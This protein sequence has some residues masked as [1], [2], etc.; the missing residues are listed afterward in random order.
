MADWYN[1]A[2]ARL[3]A[4]PSRDERLNVGIIVFDGNRLDVRPAR[5]LDKIRA[6]SAAIDSQAVRDSILRLNVLD[7]IVQAEGHNSLT[8]R[9]AALRLICPLELSELGRFESHSDA[10]YE[11]AI[12]G[13]L[14]RLV[15]PEPAQLRKP[16]RRSKL[17]T[18]LKAAFRSERVL[19]KKGDDLST[20]RI[21]PNWQLARG[22]SADL[23]LQNGAMHV[24]ETVDAQSDEISTRK[25][26]SDI[27][28]SALV[29]EQA[30]MTF[31]ETETKGRLVYSA[32]A[33]NESLATPSLRAAEHQGAELINWASQADRV[34]FITEISHLA[35]P[36]E[37]RSVNKAAGIN[38]STQHKLALN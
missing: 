12:S 35:V 19:A 8:E 7:H 3:A 13:I 31:G 18:S 23:V 20:H 6:I 32:S 38:A 34:R 33:S 21:V 37:K 17:L 29:L 4:H 25:L 36:L 30:R 9:L 27:A 11:E 15:E 24:I 28:V 2:V 22:L 5:N 10:A 26:I 16:Q 14:S 1:F